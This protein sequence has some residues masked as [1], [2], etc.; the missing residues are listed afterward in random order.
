MRQTIIVIAKYWFFTK[1][2]VG[3][4]VRN[5]DVRENDCE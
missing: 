3:W 2:I 1:E 5:S 4:R